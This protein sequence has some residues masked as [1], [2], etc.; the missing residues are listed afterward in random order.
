[1]NW[2]PDKEE[3]RKFAIAMLVG[4][5]FLGSIAAWRWHSITPG[6]IGFWVTGFSLAVGATLPFLGRL[7]Y[8]AVY[9]PTSIIGHFISKIVLFGVFSLFFVPIAMLLRLLGKDLLRLRPKKPRAVWITTNHVNNM[10]RYY[11]QF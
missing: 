6:A 9:L 10:S 8:L 11:R 7:T 3:R 4:F 5:A 2:N 1:V